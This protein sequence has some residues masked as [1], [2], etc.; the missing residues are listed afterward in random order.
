MYHTFGINIG[1]SH[2]Q[3]MV[4]NITDEHQPEKYLLNHDVYALIARRTGDEAWDDKNGKLPVLTD[5]TLHVFLKMYLKTEIPTYYR[6][7]ENSPANV[8]GA[9]AADESSADAIPDGETD[10]EKQQREGLLPVH[11]TSLSLKEKVVLNPETVLLFITAPWY[12]L[13]QLCDLE[14]K[15]LCTHSH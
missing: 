8:E 10:E 7:E 15:L 11:V 9:D 4:L 13:K 1:S 2:P 14:S 3:I 5:E 6:S 12:D